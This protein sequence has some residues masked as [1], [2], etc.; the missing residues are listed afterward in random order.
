M[1]RV[2]SQQLLKSINQQKVLHLI[3]NEEPISRVELAELTGLTQQTVTNIVNRLLQE[4]LVVEGTPIGSSGGRKPVPLTVNVMNMF[5]IGIELA[6]KYVR[7]AL[8]NFR[9]DLVGEARRPVE[10]YLNEDH[11]LATV[12]EVIEELL[13]LTPE[14]SRIKGIGLSIQG[15]VDSKQGIALR[16]PGLGWGRFPLQERLENKYDM[17]F[18][19][20]NDVNLLAIN[21]NMHGSL[22][23]SS[24]NLTLKFDYGIGG[25]IVADNQLVTGSTFGAGEF[26]HYKAFTGANAYRCHCGGTGCLTTLASTSG[27]AV[28]VGLT[29][30]EFTEGV[31]AG[32]PLMAALYETVVTALCLAVSNVITFLNPDHVLMTGKLLEVLGDRLIPAMDERI[33]ANVPETCRGVRLSYMRQKPDE[34]ALAA[35]LVMKR[36][37]EVPVNSLSL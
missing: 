2:T 20:E 10:R 25:A 21:E 27:L 24:N 17:S 8:H 19:L 13:E 12:C 11:I 5:A 32:E 35:G 1:T 7:G 26:G 37:F 36:V 33:L 18:Y 9:Y 31:R 16:L 15:L 3:F 29:L 30:D 23:G 4:D 6:G 14:R 34:S 28:N 22:K